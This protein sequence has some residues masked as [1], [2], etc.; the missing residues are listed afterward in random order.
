MATILGLRKVTK[1]D[2]K[3]LF[4]WRNDEITRQNSL[5]S[6][7]VTLID[8]KEYIQKIITTPEINQ[9]I[10]EY[11]DE[12]V[13]T[14]REIILENNEIELS[15]TVSPRYRGKKIGQIMMSMYLIEKKGTFLCE[16]KVGNVSSISMIKK[17]GFVLSKNNDKVLQYKLIQY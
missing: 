7:M 9:F 14:I 15:Y 3:V 6:Q 10:L 8:H 17:L 12:P 5:N 2:W 16:I 1:N 13:G 4:D 11:N